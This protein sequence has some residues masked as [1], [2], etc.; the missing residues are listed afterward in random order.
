MRKRVITGWIWAAMLVTSCASPRRETVRTDYRGVDSLTAL[1]AREVCVDMTDVV[2][3]ASTD[4]A[5]TIARIGRVEIRRRD[6]SRVET[7]RT[8]T[9]ASATEID[10]KPKSRWRR[11]RSA[12]ILIALLAAGWVGYKLRL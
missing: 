5:E 12:A 1:L 8:E 2:I 11:W 10:T 9:K 6:A 4:S 3:T 7:R